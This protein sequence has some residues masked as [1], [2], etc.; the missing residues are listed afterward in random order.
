LL[1]NLKSNG[2]IISEPNDIIEKAKSLTTQCFE[3]IFE[4]EI[5]ELDKSNLD[6]S[7]KLASKQELSADMKNRIAKIDQNTQKLQECE[8]FIKDYF[9]IHRRNR[10]IK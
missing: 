5:E 9:K 2:D 6:L 7:E 3:R 1:Q 10:K 4:K 8:P